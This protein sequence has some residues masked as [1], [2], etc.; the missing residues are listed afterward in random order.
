MTI[1]LAG[2]LLLLPII[3]LHPDPPIAT[4]WVAMAATAMF[5]EHLRRSKLLGVGKL[6]TVTR[7]LYRLCFRPDH[8]CIY[9]S[10]LLVNFKNPK[11]EL[12]II[13]PHI[14][15]I[16]RDYHLYI[17]RSK[18]QKTDPEAITAS[19]FFLPS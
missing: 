18:N 2:S 5:C 6:L 10:F 8:I 9:K 13:K 17:Q 15:I 11:Y 14:F 16:R 19:I 12:L 1:S 3:L 4:G 7:L